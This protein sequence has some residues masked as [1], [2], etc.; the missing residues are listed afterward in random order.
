MGKDAET[1][2]FLDD[3]DFTFSLDSRSTASH[4]MTSIEMTSQPIVFRASYRD[5][6]LITTIVNKAI[7][8]YT[9][10]TQKRSDVDVSKTDGRT[11]AL[12]SYHPS[13][14]RKTNR[15]ATSRQLPVGKANV[16]LSKEQV[17]LYPL[18]YAHPWV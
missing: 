3:I 7:E 10:S 15:P 17:E 16:V 13:A 11:S 6:N 12:A 2:R 14:S 8:L 9:E 18:N 1:V 4:Q 5:I